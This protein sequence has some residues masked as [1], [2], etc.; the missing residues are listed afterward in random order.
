MLEISQSRSLIP[1]L[2]FIRIN[3]TY[4]QILRYSLCNLPRFARI[5][6]NR[7]NVNCENSQL[8]CDRYIPSLPHLIEFNKAFSYVLNPHLHIFLCPTS[9]GYH[10]RSCHRLSNRYAR[11]TSLKISKSLMKIGNVTALPSVYRVHLTNMPRMMV[12]TLT[13]IVGTN[14]TCLKALLSS[15]TH[16]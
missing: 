9:V 1:Y 16:Y 3:H 10:H 6:K 8:C 5:K 13:Q 14:T 7:L 2:N 4:V 11:I 12:T 15:K